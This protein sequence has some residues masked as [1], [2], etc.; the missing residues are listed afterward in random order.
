[1]SVFYD[2]IPKTPKR[3]CAGET[4]WL[5]GQREAKEGKIAV[6]QPNEQGETFAHSSMLGMLE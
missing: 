4:A 5:G 1:M 6:E 3:K 2:G